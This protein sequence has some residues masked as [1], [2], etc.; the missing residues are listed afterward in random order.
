MNV[1]KITM[2]LLVLAVGV[3][4]GFAVA[5]QQRV[6]PKTESLQIDA[7]ELDRLSAQPSLEEAIMKIAAEKMRHERRPMETLDVPI[8]VRITKSAA[9]PCYKR[10]LLVPGSNPPICILQNCV[11]SFTQ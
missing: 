11:I 1:K 5:Q 6:N 2:A 3:I 10:C 9:P 8:T 7:T 4:G